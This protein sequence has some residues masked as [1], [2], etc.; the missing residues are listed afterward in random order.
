MFLLSSVASLDRVALIGATSGV[1]GGTN[2]LYTINNCQEKEDS[3]NIIT[4]MILV[5][6]FTVYVLLDP[7][8][9]FFLLLML[10]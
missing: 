10:L 5:F 3:P 7:G 6:D 9:Y 8:A 1:D 4:G 2:H